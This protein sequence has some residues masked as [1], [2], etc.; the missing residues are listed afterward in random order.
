M[1]STNIIK[2]PA[3][4]SQI[5]THLL[6]IPILLICFI[7]C[8][9]DVL[10]WIYSRYMSPESYYSHGFIIPFISGYLIWQNREELGKTSVKKSWWGFFLIIFS[11]LVHIAGTILYVFSLSGFS[12]FLLI[13]GITLFLFGKNITGIILFPLGY[14]ILML[15]L[16]MALIGSI[17]FP[18]K[19]FVAKAGAEIIS[20]LGI[21]ISREGF[22]IT[23]PAGSLLVGNPCSG[24]RS[25]IS[26][27]AL[28]AILAYLSNISG[29]KKYLLFFLS[30]PVA[31]LSNVIRV[32]ILILISHFWG[33]S[34]A[35]PD[36][37]WHGASGVF[38]FILG[39][40]ALFCIGKLLEWKT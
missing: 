2:S 36:S 10:T 34:A 18:M 6:F 5:K 20:I 37:F 4:S 16:P 29:I 19:M 9:Y 28:G 12:I 13:F 15:P 11:V 22:H 32:P 23:I 14:L 24:L 33:L 31:I 25:L 40:S 7:A 3:L 17:S 39:G 35:A 38:V 21:P 1:N 8:Y 26:F 27:L 30:F